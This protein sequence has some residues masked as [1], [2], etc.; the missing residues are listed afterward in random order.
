MNFS[1]G[2]ESGKCH[3]GK[4]SSV[5]SEPCQTQRTLKHV[6]WT[7][8]KRTIRNPYKQ[9][10]DLLL[11]LCGFPAAPLDIRSI[12]WHMWAFVILRFILL[13]FQTGAIEKYLI[14][15]L[16]LFQPNFPQYQQDCLFAEVCGRKGRF[17]MEMHPYLK[18]KA[19]PGN[20]RK[21]RYEVLADLQISP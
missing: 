13:I 6:S 12:L 11:Q 21:G 19:L 10:P 14:G 18:V 3:G 4:L 9:A 8:P 5:E 7:P 15:R 17:K 1:P 2:S 16:W 20:A